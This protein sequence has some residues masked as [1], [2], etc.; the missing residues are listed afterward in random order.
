MLHYNKLIRDKVPEIMRKQGKKLQYHVAS[1]DEEFEF[2]L[3]AKLQEEI[4]EFAVRMDMDSLADVFEV[5]DAICDFYGVDVKDLKAH[6]E[7]RKIELGGFSGKIVLDG[8]EEP[9]GE[10]QSQLI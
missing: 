10:E 3:R 2:K 8:S 5:M 1:T 4:D 6:K 7:N 9:I